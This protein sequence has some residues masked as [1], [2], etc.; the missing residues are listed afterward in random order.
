MTHEEISAKF[1]D[2]VL[3]LEIPK[4]EAKPIEEKSRFISIEG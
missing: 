1:E 3:H 2:G 4:K